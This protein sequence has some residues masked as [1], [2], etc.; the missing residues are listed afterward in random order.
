MNAFLEIFFIKNGRAYWKKISVLQ[1]AVY[2]INSERMLILVSFLVQEVIYPTI[3]IST[4]R[5]CIKNW[6]LYIS[7]SSFIDISTLS[8]NVNNVVMF[9]VF[10]FSIDLSHS[11]PRGVLLS[12]ESTLDPTSDSADQSMKTFIL[13]LCHRIVYLIHNFPKQFVQIVL[14]CKRSFEILAVVNISYSYSFWKENIRI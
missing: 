9:K 4:S 11:W 8:K 7:F 5:Y 10:W 14:H 12:S 2:S 6:S 3:H 13:R 1:F